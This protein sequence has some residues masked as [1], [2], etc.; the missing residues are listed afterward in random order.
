[1]VINDD[2]KDL[3]HLINIYNFFMTLFKDDNNIYKI[4]LDYKDNKLSF[5]MTNDKNFSITKHV[6]CNKIEAAETIDLIRNNFILN[7]EINIP[8]KGKIV[9]KLP[10]I[11][12]YSY[13]MCHN[14]KNTKFDLFVTIRDKEDEQRM[15]EAHQKAIDKHNEQITK[16]KRLTKN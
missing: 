4:I 12:T 13:I 5:E 14:I 9:I 7:H 3:E 10:D 16:Q 6:K 15:N 8:F 1:M 2:V 11:N